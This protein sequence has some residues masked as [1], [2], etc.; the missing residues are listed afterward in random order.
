M[1]TYQ[2]LFGSHDWAESDDRP[3]PYPVSM[4]PR[5]EKL[6]VRLPRALKA[7]LEEAAERDGLTPEAWAE[8]VLSSNVGPNGATAG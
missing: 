1:P 8:R 6:S 2:L 5:T 7:R 3:K 4:P